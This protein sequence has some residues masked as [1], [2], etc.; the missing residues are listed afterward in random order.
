MSFEFDLD[1]KKNQEKTVMNSTTTNTSV[2][3]TEKKGIQDI[4]GKDPFTIV[5]AMCFNPFQPTKTPKQKVT[6]GK[7]KTVVTRD[8]QGRKQQISTQEKIVT[9]LEDEFYVVGKEE[10]ERQAKGKLKWFLSLWFVCKTVRKHLQDKGFEI[11]C[12]IKEY[13]KEEFKRV[14]KIVGTDFNARL[15]PYRTSLRYHGSEAFTIAKFAL[16]YFLKNPT[17]RCLFCSKRKCYEL[18]TVKW[19]IPSNIKSVRECFDCSSIITNEKIEY[20]C[21]NN[22]LAMK[23][24]EKLKDVKRTGYFWETDNSKTKRKFGTAAKIRRYPRSAIFQAIEDIKA[25]KQKKCMWCMLTEAESSKKRTWKKVC[26]REDH[27][28]HSDCLAERTRLGTHAF[29]NTNIAATCMFCEIGL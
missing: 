1:F 16:K 21:D 9:F 15:G 2:V 10:L 14:N 7:T 12:T 20:I 22:H 11:G 13:N 5:L 29:P 24:R 19:W 3:R 8:N 23:V 26:L 6:Y 25:E 4:I 18:E 27:F 28:Y 17:K